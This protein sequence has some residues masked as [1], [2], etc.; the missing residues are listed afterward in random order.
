[1]VYHR[2]G[3]EFG[4]VEMIVGKRPESRTTEGRRVATRAGRVVAV[5]VSLLACF[6]G[7]HLPS[8][9]AAA[10]P[11]D[12]TAVAARRAAPA[13]ETGPGRASPTSETAV[14]RL[15][16]WS[17]G[18][19]DSRTVITF[20]M[21]RGAPVR[22]FGLADPTRVVIDLPAGRFEPAMTA[23]HGDHGLISAWR[24]G[25]FAAGRSRLVL[26]TRGPVTITRAV[27]D[28]AQ[29]K[30][31]PRLVLELTP[32]SRDEMARAGSIDLAVDGPSTGGVSALTEGVAA[33]KADRQA[34]PPRPSPAHR[35]VVVI[36]AGHGGVDAGTVSPAT[37]TPEKTVVL[38]MARTLARKLKATGRYDVVTTRDDDVFLGLGERVRI[39]RAHK[40]DLFLSI[41]A[42]AEY[43]HSVRGA[44]IYTLAEKASDER[45]A[46]LA[47]KENKSDV[48]AGHAVEEVEPEVADILA[49][50]TLRETRRL[51]HVFAR[52]LL[53]AYRRQGRLVKTQPHRQAGLKV[54][55]AHD[56]PS[57]LVEIGFLSNKEDEAL[58]TSGEWRDHI[59]GS[60]V[61]AIDRYFAGRDVLAAPTKE[62]AARA[63]ASP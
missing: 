59:A 22:I 28:P 54:L 30:A 61:A 38:E 15:S 45:A 41:H 25:A 27:F 47:A 5:W 52:D 39:A 37:G 10:T 18:G 49:D 29:G 6:L 32:G 20:E 12:R 57:A 13:D 46:E 2:R 35:P 36:D 44:T 1:M 26:D 33:P 43:D 51:S 53:E 16:G 55:R 56:I 24:F 14:L 23:G 11:A 21:S 60:L 58:M 31:K 63:P 34:I 19:D 48:L 8:H 42:D 9:G 40:A 62:G 3:G 4:D 17:I 7:S 50:L